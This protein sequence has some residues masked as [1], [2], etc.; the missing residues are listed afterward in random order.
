MEGV[1]RTSHNAAALHTGNGCTMAG[2]PTDSFQGS[3]NI[4]LSAKSADNCDVNAWGQGPNQ[5]CSLGFP[6]R[7]FGGAWNEDGGGVYATLWDDT[8][9]RVWV[10]KRQCIPED[11]RCESPQPHTWGL[12]MAYFPFGQNC[13]PETFGELRVVINLTF[14]GD[15]AGASWPIAGCLMKGPSCDGYVREQP[16]AFRDAYWALRHVRVYKQ[17]G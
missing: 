12:P 1:H 3:W 15:W 16:Q 5:G 6:D 7:T 17:A 13:P 4:A 8:G 2:A 9:I 11:L 14:C 10:F